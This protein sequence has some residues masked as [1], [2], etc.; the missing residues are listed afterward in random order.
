MHYIVSYEQSADDCLECKFWQFIALRGMRF[1]LDMYTKY[2]RKSK[3]HGWKC[4]DF[5][6]RIESRRCTI[7]KPA[8]PIEV[9]YGVRQSIISEIDFVD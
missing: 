2:V 5:W 4:V 1:E 6:S 9:K 7:D 8:I 3:R